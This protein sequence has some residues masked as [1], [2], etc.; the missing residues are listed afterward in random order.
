MPLLHPNEL[1]ASDR[2]ETLLARFHQGE[3][4]FSVSDHRAPHLLR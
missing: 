2:D 1:M 3:A 4:R